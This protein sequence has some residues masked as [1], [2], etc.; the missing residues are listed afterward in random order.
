[1]VSRFKMMLAIPRSPRKCLRPYADHARHPHCYNGDELGMTNIGFDRD[2]GLPRCPPERIPAPEKYRR[3]PKAFPHQPPRQWLHALSMDDSP[4][5]GFT[6]GTSW[7]EGKSGKLQQPECRQPE[8]TLRSRSILALLRRLVALAG[9]HAPLVY[10]R[11]SPRDKD[12]SLHA[13][14]PA[15]SM[16][17]AG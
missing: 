6:T 2:R 7:L 5:A 14:I 11:Y 3:G 4:Q 15:N 17:N 16:A 1:M 13:L 9:S 10:G 12:N 8:K